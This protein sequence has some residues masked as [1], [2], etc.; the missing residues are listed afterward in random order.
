M[1]K[2]HTDALPISQGMSNLKNLK[3][4]SSASKEK[5]VNTSHCQLTF[6]EQKRPLVMSKLGDP[7][8]EV[9]KFDGRLDYVL[10]E[11]QVTNVLGAIG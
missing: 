11:Q 5:I 4:N 9:E 6:Q 1:L 8:F 10:W 2:V 7:R 3:N